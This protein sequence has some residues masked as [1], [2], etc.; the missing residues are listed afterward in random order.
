VHPPM[1][2]PITPAAVSETFFG[3]SAGYRS[4]K[5]DR[6]QTWTTGK[7]EVPYQFKGTLLET[8]AGG[9]GGGLV[10][11]DYRAGVVE[12]LFQPLTV[13]DLLN[14]E[15]T[16]GSQIRYTVEGTATNSAAAVAEGGVKPESTVVLSE[17]VEEI[18]KLATVIHISDELL[19]DAPA[20]QSYL[21][22]RLTLFVRITE[23]DQLLYGSGT[24]PN[25]R[26]VL[27]RSGSQNHN[28]G[29]FTNLD[30]IRQMITKSR[31][32]FVEPDGLL[33]HPA[34]WENIELLKDSQGG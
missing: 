23:E 2:L 14:T 15:N 28:R 3:K 31:T 4:I 34:P 25:L 11:P 18:R 21:N 12:T 24:A 13:A 7:V 22:N 8:T 16:T 5:G 20:V 9:P 26:G 1:S 10:P 33:L 30:A 27:N 32:S 17:T 6:P 29:T 19:D